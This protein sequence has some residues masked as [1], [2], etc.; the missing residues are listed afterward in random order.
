M[1]AKI[2]SNMQAGLAPPDRRNY[3]RDRSIIGNIVNF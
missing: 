3:G 2:A 1:E